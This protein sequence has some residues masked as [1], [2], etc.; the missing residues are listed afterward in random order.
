MSKLEFR[1][2]TKE[3][4]ML[5]CSPKVQGAKNFAWVATKGQPM[6]PK[7]CIMTCFGQPADSC[8]IAVQWSKNA[9]N[10]GL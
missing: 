5:T 10:R 9:K 2:S 8:N 7:V 6:I 4:T 3:L 1:M